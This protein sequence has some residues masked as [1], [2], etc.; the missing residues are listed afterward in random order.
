MYFQHITYSETAPQ[1]HCSQRLK[2]KNKFKRL[3]KL[4][5]FSYFKSVFRS[6]HR[7]FK[8]EAAVQWISTK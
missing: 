1:R 7:Q 2:I 3:K 6:I 8:L 5:V 4:L